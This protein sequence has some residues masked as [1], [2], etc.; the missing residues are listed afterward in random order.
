MWPKKTEVKVF[1]KAETCNSFNE[2]Y[3]GYNFFHCLGV[4]TLIPLWY[5]TVIWTVSTSAQGFEN[6]RSCNF[7]EKKSL[8]FPGPN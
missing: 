2:V 6:Y 3:V 8:S 4:S 7:I 1:L 5:E